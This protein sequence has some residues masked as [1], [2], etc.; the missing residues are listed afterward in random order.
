MKP[1]L[2]LFIMYII[3]LLNFIVG[4][5]SVDS[6]CRC[7][8]IIYVDVDKLVMDTIQY[9]FSPLKNDVSSF[10]NMTFSHHFGWTILKG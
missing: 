2:Y 4:M 7:K 8:C 1:Q 3:V 6:F 9:M 5:I 10:L